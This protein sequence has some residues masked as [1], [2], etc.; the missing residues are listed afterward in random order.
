MSN[1]EQHQRPDMLVE[2][3]WLQQYMED[4]E[5]RIVD[6]GPLDGYKRG[7]IPGAMGLNRD[8]FKDPS[9]P[10]LVMPPDQF[11]EAMGRVGIGNE[12]NV[13][14]YDEWGGLYA[15]RLWWL[16][17]MHGHEKVWVLNGGWNKWLKEGREV[18]QPSIDSYH[19]NK[20]VTPHA[21]A[22][23]VPRLNPEY[24]CT[25]DRLLKSLD[26]PGFVT[27]DVRNIGEYTGANTRGNK[28]RGH[29]PGT[30]HIEW[31]RAVTDDG[32]RTFRPPDELREM[33]E[34]AGITPEKEIVVY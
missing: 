19:I 22:K 28:R 30:V 13:V 23:F 9:N 29:I 3:E 1:G 24:N 34:S 27:L 15:S 25:V 10:A 21:P 5:L 32:F 33:Y 8:Y 17:R 14:A 31:I 2:T 16:L 18:A 4:P 26:K 7:H 6:M 12:H 20:V 11:A